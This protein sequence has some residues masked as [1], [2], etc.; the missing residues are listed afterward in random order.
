MYLLFRDEND[1]TCDT[2]MITMAKVVS[3]CVTHTA[4]NIE[5][6]KEEEEKSVSSL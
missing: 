6:V 5:D 4:R 3:D 2:F 1:N